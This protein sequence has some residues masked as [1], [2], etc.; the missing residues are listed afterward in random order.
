MRRK[1]VTEPNYD[2]MYDQITEPVLTSNTAPMPVSAIP[3]ESWFTRMMRGIGHF[4]AAVIKKINQ[5]LALGLTILLLLL[6]TRFALYFFGL[7][8]SLFSQW[9]FQLSA[10]LVLPF[11]NLLPALPFQGYTLDVS[12]LIAIIVYALAVTL[13]RQ[14]LKVLVARP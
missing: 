10:P 2:Y 8:L 13:V 3:R 7:K 4:F 11:N 1:H 5:L 12:T 9:V 6:F 14:F